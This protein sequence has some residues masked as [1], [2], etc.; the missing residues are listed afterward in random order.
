MSSHIELRHLTYF[1]AVAE[2][3]HFRRAAEKLF[4]SQPGLSR[5]IKQMEA[6]LQAELFIRDKKKVSLTPAGHYLKHQAE[7]IFKHLKETKRQLQLIGGGDTGEVRIGFLGSAMQDVIPSLLL[8]LKEKLPR[9]KTSLEE[10]S[11]LSQVDAVLK[12]ELDMGFV[13]LAKVPA[14]LNKKTVFKD[15]FSLVLPESYPMLTREYEGMERFVEDNFILFSQDYSPY[16]YETIMSICSDAGFVPKVSHKSV[17]AQTIFKLVENNL[18]IAIIPT[19]LQ[20]G[21]QM[22]VK[23]IEL[24]DIKQR[25]LLSVIWKKENRNPVLQNCMDLLFDS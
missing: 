15:T 19:A 14:A 18:G 12:D 13:R 3:L 8:K 10:L 7:D 23:F 11:N 9:I 22:R 20:Y 2:E 1:L 16:Y 25:A 21:F 5:Q 4:I 6:I 24:K 17:H